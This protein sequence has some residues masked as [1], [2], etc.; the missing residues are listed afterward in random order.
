[1][2]RYQNDPL[3]IEKLLQEPGGG[4]TEP[5]GGVVRWMEETLLNGN[6]AP[7]PVERVERERAER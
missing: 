5:K 6:A 2:T 1:M 4:Y 7:L 3:A